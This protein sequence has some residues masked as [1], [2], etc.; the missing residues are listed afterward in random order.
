[1]KKAAAGRLTES[2]DRLD[3][4]GAV[5]SCRLADQQEQL[6]DEYLRLTE[7]G[8]SLVVVAQTWAEVHRVNE[9]VRTALKKKGLVAADEHMVEVLE[10]VDLTTAQKRDER[11]YSFNQI[12]VF[13]QPLHGL[14]PSPRGKL[15]GIVKRGVLLEVGGK[16]LLISRRNLDH[17][18]ICKPLTIT[19][20]QGD[21]LQIKANRLML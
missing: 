5:Q 14:A 13:N 18:N 4:M 6:A 2:F 10:K 19:L 11:F 16:A 12:I 20:A 1:M 3:R 9:R 17:I 7:E 8:Q 15:S 21:R